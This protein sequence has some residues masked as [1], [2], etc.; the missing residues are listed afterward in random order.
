MA[1]S[2]PN[3][4]PD[5][6]LEGFGELDSNDQDIPAW[7]DELPDGDETG[8]SEQT[9]RE[10]AAMGLSPEELELLTRGGDFKGRELT[11][12]EVRLIASGRISNEQLFRISEETGLSIEELRGMA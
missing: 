10:L 2:K 4:P 6:E 9:L 1:K 11:D 5:D 7:E 12:E 8:L 3:P